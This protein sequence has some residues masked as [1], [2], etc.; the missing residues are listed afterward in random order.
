[1]SL[2]FTDNTDPLEPAKSA[3]LKP[4]NGLEFKLPT[5]Y[6]NLKEEARKK[7]EEILR[8]AEEAKA[9]ATQTLTPPGGFQAG[10]ERVKEIPV[11]EY[12][13][14]TATQ[15]EPFRK[16]LGD[17]AEA[18]K[19]FAVSA[20]KITPPYHVYK[21]IKKEPVTLQ[22]ELENVAN[23]VISGV[24]TVYRA[25][26]YAPILGA[27]M[28]SWK[29]IRQ[30]GQGKITREELLNK[31]RAGITEQPG[32]G[33]I[34]SDNPNV[35]T[36]IDIAF[37]ATM[38]GGPFLKKKL[39]Q[40]NLKS[41][42][43]NRVSETLGVNANTPLEE[44]ND[45][46]KRYMVQYKDVFAGRGTPEDIAIVKELNAAKGVLEKAGVIE[47]NWS[48][49]LKV[50]ND[51]SGFIKLGGEPT[52]K[53]PKAVLPSGSKIT[54]QPAIQPSTVITGPQKSARLPVPQTGEPVEISLPF[55]KQIVKTTTPATIKPEQ[56]MISNL[57]KATPEEIKRMFEK[58]AVEKYQSPQ[59]IEGLPM[60]KEIEKVALKEQ[61]G[62]GMFQPTPEEIAAQQENELAQARGEVAGEQL[63]SQYG[64]EIQKFK[65]FLRIAGEKR[66]METGEL[67]REHIPRSVFGVSSDEVATDLGKSESEFMGELVSDLEMVERGQRSPAVVTRI[68]TKIDKIRSLAEA[69]KLD[70]NVYGVITSLDSTLKTIPSYK[71]LKPYIPAEAVSAEASEKTLERVSKREAQAEKKTQEQIFDEWQGAIRSETMSP[72][73]NIKR[74]VDMVKQ[75]TDDAIKNK[76]ENMAEKTFLIDVR[77]PEL[78]FKK[79]G[80]HDDVYMP[81][82]R[83]Q[84][85]LTRQIVKE[86]KIMNEWYKKAGRTQA[87]RDKIGAALDGLSIPETL[88]PEEHQVYLEVKSRFAELADKFGIPPEQQI[89]HYLTHIFDPDLKEKGIP[90]ELM[91][92]LEFINPSGIYNPFLEERTGAKGYKLDFLAAYDAYVRRGWRKVYLDEPLENA[93]QY[94]D[95]EGEQA[96]RYLDRYLKNFVGRPDS[97]EQWLNDNFLSVLPD[98]VKK[99]LG[100]RPFK[101]LTDSARTMVYRS[102]LGLNFKAAIRNSLQNVNSLAELGEKRFT[103]GAIDL[104]TKGTDELVNEGVLEDMIVADYEAKPLRDAMQKA[105]NVLF[106]AF[107]SVERLNRGIAYYGAKREGFAK[108][109]SEDEA[110]D[111]AKGI[112]RKTQFAYGK[113]DM[114]LIL[115]NTLGKVGFQYSSY[116]IKQAELLEGWLR[117]EGWSGR[118]KLLRYIIYGF[119]TVSAF[120]K[121]MDVDFGDMVNILPGFGPIPDALISIVKAAKGDWQGERDIKNLPWLVIPGGSAIRRTLDAAKLI[122]KGESRTQPSKSY[123]G[124][125]FKFKAPETITGKIQALLFGQYSTEEGKKYVDKLEKQNPALWKKLLEKVE[126][127]NPFEEF[128][129]KGKTGNK[130]GYDID[131]VNRILEANR[132]SK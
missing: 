29:G 12:F 18:A 59:G 98:A 93:T 118:K 10:I 103:Q 122:Q 72:S 127:S 34:F 14:P 131:E 15:A 32:V 88:T 60:G 100:P 33:E 30:Y 69:L 95:F 106:F 71:S 109:M 47:K 55:E 124:G 68:R 74:V 24:N 35:R 128:F 1:M 66:S 132:K 19:Q 108:G 56:S 125:R 126:E 38:I 37:M 87:Q 2:R 76:L 43:L 16:Y 107:E 123:P 105:D 3:K 114:P 6:S 85:S 48:Q 94:A 101:R 83:G 65:S 40:L 99:Q 97:S 26:P 63:G 11:K 42:E 117:K 41:T 75:S 21:A 17:T 51:Q 61:M 4:G 49:F 67:F 50:L 22:Q 112:V 28:E 86:V 92:A 44:V 116:P 54:R 82:R 77:T 73:Q 120:K 91:R 13:L 110:I 84:E 90:Q 104:L 96:Q 27:G 23:L 113:L 52:I 70:K 46:W 129:E 36:A 64:R 130:S 58:M 53:S 79:L 25:Q 39:G 78:V 9:K 115:Q 7:K 102:T 45:I 111:Y 80:L 62:A 57:G 119:L 5:F 31:P 89:T 20:V 8:L 121:I 81:L